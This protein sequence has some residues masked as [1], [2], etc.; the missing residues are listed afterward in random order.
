MRRSCDLV[1]CIYDSRGDRF[2]LFFFWP[3][4]LPP[5]APFPSDRSPRVVH[6]ASAAPQ[7][8]GSGAGA[9]VE[10]SGLP[11][12]GFSRHKEVHLGQNAVCRER[13]GTKPF[14][15]HLFMHIFTQRVFIYF[16][17]VNMSF[18]IV[19]LQLNF[20]PRLLFFLC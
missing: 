6:R 18:F 16:L 11:P 7:R 2:P 3:L 15:F 20:P 12:I 17:P 19:G 5:C 1:S 10:R 14:R 8:E 4:L 13:C 9:G